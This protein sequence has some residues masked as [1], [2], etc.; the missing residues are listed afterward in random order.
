MVFCGL[1]YQIVSNCR[2]KPS[3]FRDGFNSLPTTSQMCCMK[4]KTRKSSWTRKSWEKLNTIHSNTCTV[5]LGIILLI[6]NFGVSQ[7]E[8]RC[9]V[10]MPEMIIKGVQL[11]KQIVLQAITACCGYVWH[12]IVRLGFPRCRGRLH[13]RRRLSSRHNWYGDL[14]L[15][16][17]DSHSVQFQRI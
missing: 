8:L 11:S 16:T 17:I 15:K 14:S 13:T 7:R 4:E 6:S 2:A 3:K 1:S 12:A 9:A 10:S 5:R